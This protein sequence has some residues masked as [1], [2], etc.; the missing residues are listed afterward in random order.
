LLLLLL[1]LLLLTQLNPLPESNPCR[2]KRGRLSRGLP[3]PV[4]RLLRH[5]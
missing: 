4:S 5:I 2:Q 3:K 1:L